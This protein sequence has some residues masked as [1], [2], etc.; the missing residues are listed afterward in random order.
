MKNIYSVAALLCF[1]SFTAFLGSGCASTPTQASAGEFIDDSVITTKVK[2]ALVRNDETPGGAIKVET[3]KG[4]VQLSG[5][6]DTA[7]QKAE[8]GVVAAKVEGVQ[9]VTNDIVVSSTLTKSTA[10]QYIDDSVI[11]TK[12]KAALVKDDLTP[13][14]AVKVDTLKGTVQLSGFVNTPEQKL[15]AGVVAGRI[16]GVKEVVNNIVVK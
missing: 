14:G 15:Q 12:V 8:A 13:G 10:G 6:V 1:A 2:T 5:F 9:R 4:V 11:T 16:E 7:Q 3:F